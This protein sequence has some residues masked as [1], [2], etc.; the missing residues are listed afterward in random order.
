MKLVPQ[1][2][3]LY[4]TFKDSINSTI[5]A[6]GIICCLFALYQA[7]VYEIVIQD[8]LFIEVRL[9]EIDTLRQVFFTSDDQRVI[10]NAINASNRLFSEIEASVVEM[11]K[12]FKLVTFLCFLNL[13]FFV[14]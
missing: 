4:E 9:S 14:N 13:F 10:F 3:W 2:K 12:V 11:A 5:L 8:L 7:Y 6:Q 1:S